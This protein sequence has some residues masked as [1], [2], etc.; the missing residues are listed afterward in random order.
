MKSAFPLLCDYL[1]DQ[2][3]I[4]TTEFPTGY[5]GEQFRSIKERPFNSAL[6][7]KMELNLLEKVANTFATTSTNEIIELSHLEEAWT[8]NQNGK[9][10]IRYDYSFD[11]NLL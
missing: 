7:T 10:L 4:V 5:T 2:M 1:Q 8:K 9:S 11:L 6:F 3:G